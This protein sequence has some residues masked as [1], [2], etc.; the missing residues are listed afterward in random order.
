M[1]CLTSLLFASLLALLVA[2][3]PVPL[4]ATSSDALRARNC[5]NFHS[6]LWCRDSTE[7]YGARDNRTYVPRAIHPAG[8]HNVTGQYNTTSTASGADDHD[9]PKE[10]DGDGKSDTL[11]PEAFLEGDSDSGGESALGNT[12]VSVANGQMGGG[13]GSAALSNKTSGSTSSFCSLLACTSAAQSDGKVSTSTAGV[14]ISN[15][16][17][18]LIG[19]KGPL[20]IIMNSRTWRNSTSGYQNTTNLDA[21]AAWWTKK[22]TGGEKGWKFLDGRL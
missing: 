1:C 3:T 9:G 14:D 20:V 8:L 2:A 4:L 16:T 13:T 12:A 7:A 5:R 6:L 19:V 15:H 22:L 10:D 11:I 21:A 18:P 17:G